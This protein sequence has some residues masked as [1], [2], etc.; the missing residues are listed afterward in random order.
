MEE[1]FQINVIIYQVID[2]EP[3]FLLLKRTKIRGGFWQGVSGG[4]NDGETNKEAAVREL[5][6]ETG[7]KKFIKIIGDVYYFEFRAGDNLGRENVFGVE[8]QKGTIIKKSDEHSKYCWCSFEEA[9]KLL[10]YDSN[11][12]A[13]SKLYKMIKINK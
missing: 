13:F 1:F 9:L 2:N 7:I 5:W 4:V 8:V 12:I 6:E 3:L 11:K 10:K